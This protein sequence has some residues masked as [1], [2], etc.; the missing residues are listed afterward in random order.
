MRCDICGQESRSLFKA[1]HRDRGQV[2]ICEGCLRDE[3][4]ML[5]PFKGCSCC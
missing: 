2:K 5:L 1:R 4:E 3:K